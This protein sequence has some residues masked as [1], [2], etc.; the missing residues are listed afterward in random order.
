MKIL[1]L[2]GYT[3]S[4]S[5][6][7]R[8]A[9][10]LRKALMKAGHEL[11]FIDGP[12]KIELS[13]LPFEPTP[14]MADLDMRGWWSVKEGDSRYGDT[15][16]AFKT[17]KEAVERLGPFDGIFGFSQGAGL[18]ALLCK[19]LKDLVPSH[20][21]L[22]FVVM[23]SSFKLKAESAQ[24]WYETPFTVPSLHVMGTLDTLV[25]EERSMQ[26][27]NCWDSSKVNILKHPGG[28]YTPS[29]KPMLQSVVGFVNNIGEESTTKA[30]DSGAKDEGNWDEFKSLGKKA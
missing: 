28:H 3:Q 18:T 25:P 5:L 22:K 11:H 29:Q 21:P 9:S 27:V 8:K 10:G 14:E 17:V 13:E 20:P 30:E 4:G 16:D 19:A 23:Y 26:L 7:S 1:C 2:H 15:T 6:F 24:H 12:L